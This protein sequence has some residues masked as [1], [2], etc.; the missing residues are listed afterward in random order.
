LA[1][2]SRKQFLKLKKHIKYKGD[3]A[4]KMMYFRVICLSVL[5]TFISCHIKEKSPQDNKENT[6]SSV[7]TDNIAAKQKVETVEGNTEYYVYAMPKIYQGRLP[8][9]V[10]IDPHGNGKLAVNKFRSALQDYQIIVIGLNNVRNN[11]PRYDVLIKKSVEA[12][13]Q[14]LPADDVHI[15][16]S[17]F[18]GGA[19]MAFQY[20][21]NNSC[22]GVIMCGAGP[23]N[24]MLMKADFP[25]VAVSG[26][27]DFNFIEQYYS[28]A[29]P[30][31]RKPDFISLYFNGT[32]EWPPSD[33]IKESISFL[34]MKSRPLENVT[35]KPIKT[36]L[37]KK[38]SLLS[39]QEYLLA[40]KVLEKAYKTCN[41]N[42]KEIYLAELKKM[43]NNRTIKTFFLSFEEILKMEMAR[44]QDYYRCLFTKDINWWL[45]EIDKIDDKTK[46]GKDSLIT[47]SF[48]RTRAFLGV[49]IYSVTSAAVYEQR[50]NNLIEKLLILYENLEPEH[51][52]VFYFNALNAFKHNNIALCIRYL[53]QSKN[54]GFSDFTLLKKDFPDNIYKEVF[55]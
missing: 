44:H 24:N 49:L 16:Y 34:F 51:P 20:A 5:F 28:P 36:I 54:L 52:D 25:L 15:F 4:P 32:H 6:S 47:Y 48:L 37:N 30:L 38:D 13:L 33:I 41:D 12:A 29:S 55:Q 21:L 35:E 26:I 39:T 3:S 11:T 43:N 17:G 42:N 40:F 7:N 2:L 31:V 45:N 50:D 8:L 23:Q 9:F 1:N 10:L 14:E 46:E 53:E 19:R 18:S 22:E 27:K